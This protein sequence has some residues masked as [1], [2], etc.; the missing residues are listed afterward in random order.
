MITFSAT[1]NSF[2]DTYNDIRAEY[3][4]LEGRAKEVNTGHWQSLKDTPHSKTRELLHVAIE[5]RVSRTS[6]A[7]GA[8][9]QPNL[10][11]AEDHFLERVSGKPLNPGEQYKFWPWYAGGVEDHKQPGEFSHTYM[12]RFWAAEAMRQ[13]GYEPHGIRYK[14][15]DLENLLHLLKREPKTRQAYLPIWFPEDVWAASVVKQRVP[16]TLGYHFMLRDDQ[17]HCFY[18]MRS[19]DFVRYLRDDL[20]MA[21]RLVQWIIDE[22]K[23]IE[24]GQD[25]TWV[26]VIPGKLTL[27]ASSLH[28]FEGD[29]PKLTREHHEYASQSA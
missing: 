25:D 15:G 10:P 11:W 20:Y 23:D 17:L 4:N 13:N 16:C 24:E 29:I 6:G 28:I 27:F 21:G 8:F 18:P 3:L 22:L 12:E 9:M 5:A 19:V 1:G 2:N 7:W 14:V 26:D